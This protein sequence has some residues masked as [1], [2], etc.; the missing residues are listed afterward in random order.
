MTSV[1]DRAAADKAWMS[2]AERALLAVLCAAVAVILGRVVLG[3]PDDAAGL[4]PLVQTHLNDSGV[5]NPVTAVLLNFRGYDTLLEV[6]VL[7]VAVFG[8]RLVRDGAPPSHHGARSTSPVLVGLVRVIVPP[9][10]LIGGF[11]TWVG[12][13]E[14]GGAFQGGA[15][16]GA[17]WVLLMLAGWRLPVRYRGWPLRSA[18]IVGFAVFLS[19]AVA[20][21][22]H[23]GLLEYPRAWAGPLILLIESALL[24]S[25]SALLASLISGRP[26][27]G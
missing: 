17:A 19:I 3:A 24:V 8:T 1:R 15:V 7:L 14:P 16:I 27:E 26:D 9:M 23:G 5:T 18:L 20:T 25:I 12:A 21:T 10:I 6:G 11:L 4:V 2:T 22:I 13:T